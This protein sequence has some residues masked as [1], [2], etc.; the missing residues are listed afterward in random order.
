[1]ITI[2]VT[3]FTYFSHF[4]ISLWTAVCTNHE[5]NHLAG[6]AKKKLE[7]V[8]KFWKFQLCQ[9]RAGD[10]QSKVKCDA[11]N[12]WEDSRLNEPAHTIPLSFSAVRY[13][14]RVFFSWL[15]FG[16]KRGKK[17]FR[18]TNLE[19]ASFFRDVNYKIAGGNLDV[20]KQ[21]KSWKGEHCKFPLFGL[22]YDVPPQVKAVS[23]CKWNTVI[24][25]VV[26]FQSTRG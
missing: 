6:F 25:N 1:M 8:A 13:L 12:P 24:K 2:P 11:N 21:G 17:F 4:F 16:S 9:A 20:S 18:K 14:L 5:F 7:F 10:V 3:L 19:N 22:I 23:S 15:H 26:V